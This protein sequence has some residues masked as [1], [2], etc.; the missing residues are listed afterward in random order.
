LPP[1]RIVERVRIDRVEIVVAWDSITGPRSVQP[2]P[3]ACGSRL[4]LT[5]RPIADRFRPKVEIE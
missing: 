2:W 3:G 4:V 5:V 1:V